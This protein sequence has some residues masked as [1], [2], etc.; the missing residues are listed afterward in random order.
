MNRIRLCVVGA[1]GRM[2]VEILRAADP[3]FEISGAIT[4]S[5]SPNEGHTLDDLGLPQEG[6]TIVGP[7]SLEEMLRKSDVYLS[8]TT[9]E[10]EMQNI[11]IAAR[12][13]KKIV[14]GTTGLSAEQDKSIRSAIE[15]QTEAVLAANFSIGINFIAGL[16]SRTSSL[17]KSF[18]A[19]L[20]EIHHTGKMDSP[21]GTALHLSDIL[22]NARGYSKEIHGRSGKGRR[23]SDEM[24]VVAMRAG[25]VPGI[26]EVVL[27]GPNEMIR[28]EHSAF[29]RRVFADGAL[30]AARW[31]MGISDRK[32]HTMREVLGV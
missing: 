24:E 3:D 12:L 26:H 7:D 25:G 29:S 1:D 18:D 13:G 4:H 10:A 21:S 9:P 20:M 16:L 32:I 8:F 11:P 15:G 27:A 30:L 2:G 5:G 6:V 19:S 14:M 28:I 31:V 22:R 23:G 17:P